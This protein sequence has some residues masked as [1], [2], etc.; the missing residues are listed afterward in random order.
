M[1]LVQKPLRPAQPAKPA[2]QPDV[3]QSAMDRRP[4]INANQRRANPGMPAKPPATA[5]PAEPA[6]MALRRAGQAGTGSAA[7]NRAAAAGLGGPQIQARSFPA[8]V[9][10]MTLPPPPPRN[11]RGVPGGGPMG[12][13]PPSPPPPTPPPGGEFDLNDLR[14]G[15]GAEGGGPFSGEA[16]RNFQQNTQGMSD[17]DIQLQ[18]AGSQFPPGSQKPLFSAN[19][20]PEI[21]QRLQ[22]LRAG[23]GAAGAAGGQGAPGAQ[24]LGA[25]A[26][27]P[28]PSLPD[29]Y[30]PPPTR[31]AGAGFDR[32]M[33]Y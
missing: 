5:P 18:M 33:A 13:A 4:R 20:P 25:P 2:L 16:L 24:P 11:G 21:M 1:T 32:R 7:G 14:S 26:V 29:Y 28:P 31:G 12:A 8:P 23:R 9:D 30:Q 27:M 6:W 3:I 19:L 17:Q 10:S 15:A 22:A